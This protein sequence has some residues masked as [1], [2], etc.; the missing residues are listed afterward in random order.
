MTNKDAAMGIV[1]GARLILEGGWHLLSTGLRAIYEWVTRDE[2]DASEEEEEKEADGRKNPRKN[3]K[4]AG[5][6]PAAD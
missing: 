6:T 5:K 3:R 2:E 4:R 1:E